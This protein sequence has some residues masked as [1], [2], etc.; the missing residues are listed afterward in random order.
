MP[1]HNFMSVLSKIPDTFNLINVH[2]AESRHL[3][4]VPHN[5]AY[6]KLARPSVSWPRNDNKMRMDKCRTRI[7]S[8][9]GAI[10]WVVRH[11]TKKPAREREWALTVT[12]SLSHWYCGTAVAVY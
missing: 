7:E 12:H 4:C 11:A 8:E 2:G 9:N 5:P 1:L 6:S 3:V 10:C